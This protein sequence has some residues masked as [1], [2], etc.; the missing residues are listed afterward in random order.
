MTYPV[1]NSMPRW[2]GLPGTLAIYGRPRA[3]WGMLACIFLG[4]SAASTVA[5]GQK[6][7]D[8]HTL[9]RR[10]EASYHGI[11]DYTALFFKRERIDGELL[12]LE[13]IE[14][15]FQEPFKVYMAWQEPHTGREI[16]FVEGQNDDKILVNPGGL[17][18]F[19]RLAL[20]PESSLATRN[21]HHTVREVGLENT[22]DLLMQQ[23]RRGVDEGVL[24]LRFLGHD[25]VGRRPAYRLEFIC[26]A[27]KSAGYYARRGEIWLDKEHYLPVRL[28][29]YNWE[30]E[31][32][33]YYEYRQLRL[34]PGLKS[35]AF[36][37]DPVQ[38]SRTPANT[39][40]TFSP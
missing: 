34:N 5:S 16:A 27:G 13:K 8:P 37:L 2:R 26:H 32:H 11:K 39:E 12:P 4:L 36:E 25:S 20:D 15:R 19:M 14:L 23:Y 21:A 28:S 7:I 6:T 1:W 9:I 40:A 24:T 33:A 30:N 38:K 10:M 35:A 18:Q 31:L 22:V 29:V 17:L 3:L